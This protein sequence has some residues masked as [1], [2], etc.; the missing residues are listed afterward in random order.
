M[1]AV[2]DFVK[3][4][5]V[6]FVPLSWI[7]GKKFAWP[8]TSKKTLTPAQAKLREDPKSQPGDGWQLLP[9]KIIRLCGKFLISAYQCT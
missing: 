9:V 3:E 7:K 2:V 1:F 6:E 5:M 4:G 8:T